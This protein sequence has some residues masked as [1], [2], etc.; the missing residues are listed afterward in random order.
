MTDL[1]EYQIYIGYKD[2][3]LG[4]EILS[5]KEITEVLSAYFERVKMG[6]S[7]LSLKGGYYYEDGWYDTENTL[8]ISIIGDSETDI[9]RI[10][11]AISMF[12]NQECSL[13]VKYPLKMKYM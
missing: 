11:N 12:M 1:I 2:P 10:T 9:L 7:L 8:C 13:V 3:Q 5:E 4:E 6:F